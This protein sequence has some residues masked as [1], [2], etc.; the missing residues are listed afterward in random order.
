MFKGL[1]MIPHKGEIKLIY[2]QNFTF[3]RTSHISVAIR[4]CFIGFS[5]SLLFVVSFNLYKTARGF[6]NLYTIHFFH[7]SKY[8]LIEIPTFAGRDNSGYIFSSLT[9]TA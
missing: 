8:W 2:F 6:L 4:P 9:L 5:F 7:N 1:I 3:N